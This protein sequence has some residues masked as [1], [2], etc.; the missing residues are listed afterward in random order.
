V[1]IH[2]TAEVQFQAPWSNIRWILPAWTQKR[3]SRKGLAE[4]QRS[5]AYSVSMLSTP[6]WGR[7]RT[8]PKKAFAAWSIN[9]PARGTVP[10]MEQGK[11]W[12]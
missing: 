3:T 5:V 8:M 9:G 10:V 1:D 6:A 7:G 2:Y 4:T 12:C 11:S